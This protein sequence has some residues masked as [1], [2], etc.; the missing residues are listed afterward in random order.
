MKGQGKSIQYHGQIE[1]SKGDELYNIFV[2]NIRAGIVEAYASA[3]ESE[4]PSGF[5][6]WKTQLG[7]LVSQTLDPA[8]SE[9]QIFRLDPAYGSFDDTGFPLTMADGEPLSKSAAKKLRKV[10]D[11]HAKRHLKYTPPE[12]VPPQWSTWLE[13]CPCQVVAG[14]FGKRQGLDIESDMGPFCHVLTL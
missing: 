12:I 9:T 3:I 2:D 5:V 11:A 8:I 1:K 4:L 13:H 10:Y 7:K 6:A 14:S